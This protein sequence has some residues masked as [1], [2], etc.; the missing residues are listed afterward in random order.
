VGLFDARPFVALAPTF[1]ACVACQAGEL[2]GGR[3]DRDLAVSDH[4]APFEPQLR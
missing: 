2:S 3:D 1:L 4:G